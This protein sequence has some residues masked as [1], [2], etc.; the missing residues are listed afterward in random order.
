MAAPAWQTTNAQNFNANT[1]A[2]NVPTG[3]A[4]NDIVLAFATIFPTSVQTITPPSGWAQIGTDLY[5]AS[6]QMQTSAFWHRAAGS[7]SGTYTF[8]TAASEAWTIDLMRYSGAA[9]SGSPIDA[10]TDAASTG[11]GATTPALSLNTNGPN[12][13]LVWFGVCATAGAA[14]NLTVPTGFTISEWAGSRSKVND[15]TQAVAGSTGT[16]QGSTSLG[17]GDA[18]NVFLLALKPPDVSNPAAFFEVL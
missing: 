16:V 6:G 5:Q 3:V 15:K 4:A 11:L 17:G 18:F 7:E 2:P 12:R 10:F 1:A 14:A 9:N 8:T 13:L